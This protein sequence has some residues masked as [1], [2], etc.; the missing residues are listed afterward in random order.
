MDVSL[1]TEP[2][3]GRSLLCPIREIS[4]TAPRRRSTSVADEEFN[5]GQGCRGLAAD[6]GMRLGRT[7]LGD[8]ERIGIRGAFDWDRDRESRDKASK[9]FDDGEGICIMES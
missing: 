3:F 2:T 8:E 4:S 9:K 7:P 6:K 1:V 5:A